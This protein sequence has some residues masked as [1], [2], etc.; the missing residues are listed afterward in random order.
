VSAKWGGARE[1]K[2]DSEKE[3]SGEKKRKGGHLLQ[4]DVNGPG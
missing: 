1:K 3:K 4:I 2:E